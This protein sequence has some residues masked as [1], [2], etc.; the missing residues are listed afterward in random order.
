MIQ[1]ASGAT[2]MVLDAMFDYTTA[3]ALGGG[4]ARARRHDPDDRHVRNSTSNRVLF[5]PSVNDEMGYTFAL[6]YPPGALDNPSLSLVGA[7][8]TCFW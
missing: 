3:L 5:G 1:R 8:N 7:R 6:A 2:E 4:E